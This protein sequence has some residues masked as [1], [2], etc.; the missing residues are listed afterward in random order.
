[1]QRFGSSLDPDV[2]ATPRASIQPK[3]L[4]RVLGSNVGM[5]AG[6]DAGKVSAHALRQGVDER[7]VSHFVYIPERVN[8]DALAARLRGDGLD[9]EMEM[10]ADSTNWLVL[11]HQIA[12]NDDD[13][14]EEMEEKLT[15][16]AVASG[17][18]YDGCERGVQ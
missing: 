5:Q 13:A 11:V 7:R 3:A 12:T 10:G 9:V 14:I 17:G 1:M 8:A 16:L 18:E 4:E 15:K 6:V 2:P